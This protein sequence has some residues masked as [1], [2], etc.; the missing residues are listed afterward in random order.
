M[1][2]D[3]MEKYE[4]LSDEEKAEKISTRLNFLKDRMK[5]FKDEQEALKPWI[6]EHAETL[7]VDKNDTEA[8]EVIVHKT[9]VTFKRPTPK[10]MTQA[11]ADVLK[12]RFIEVFEDDE[13]HEGLKKF[14]ELYEK[15][16]VEFKPLK[17]F[18]DN[19]F[20]LPKSL[21]KRIDST[22]R[23]EKL[24]KTNTAEVK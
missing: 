2:E 14:K 6:R 21:R 16:P 9:T 1:A 13:D 18:A 12:E 5:E 24:W 7:R 15:K 3:F 10:N 17:G 20:S 4:G 8:E 22:M 23:K 19:Y 11:E